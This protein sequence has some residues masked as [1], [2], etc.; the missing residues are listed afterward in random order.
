MMASVQRL[1]WFFYNLGARLTSKDEV[2]RYREFTSPSPVLI[3]GEI[4]I[5]LVDQNVL[6]FP[7]RALKQASG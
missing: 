3:R 7:A 1:R 6:Q 5:G 4:R 2:I